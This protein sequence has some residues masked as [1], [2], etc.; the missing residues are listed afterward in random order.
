[1]FTAS[2]SASNKSKLE[3]EPRPVVTLTSG[4][5]RSLMEKVS[6]LARLFSDRGGLQGYNLTVTIK[7]EA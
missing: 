3:P 1:M 4:D 5:I 2:V 7:E 6:T